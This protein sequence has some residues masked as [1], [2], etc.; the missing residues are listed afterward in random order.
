MK[1]Y[2]VNEDMDGIGDMKLEKQENILSEPIIINMPSIDSWNITA[3]RYTCRKNKVKG[4]IKMDREQL[5]IE[6]KKIIHNFKER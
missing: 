3:L 5:I 6:V 2:N 1:F 4:Y